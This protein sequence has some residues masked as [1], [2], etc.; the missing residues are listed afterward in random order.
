MV[1]KRICVKSSNKQEAAEFMYVKKWGGVLIDVKTTSANKF[2]VK[3]EPLNLMLNGSSIYKTY[4]LRF[5]AV[6]SGCQTFV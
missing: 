6:V 3:K 2:R 1:N 4:I 5:V